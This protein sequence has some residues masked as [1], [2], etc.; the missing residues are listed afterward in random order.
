MTS[1]ATYAEV[2][3]TCS[4]SFSIV[5]YADFVDCDVVPMQACSLLLG[6]PWE[7]DNDATHHGRSNKYTFMHKV[8]K[9]LW[10]L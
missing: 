1:A 3:K 4:V 9:L 5:A 8:K 2:T 6:Y 7:H 10:F